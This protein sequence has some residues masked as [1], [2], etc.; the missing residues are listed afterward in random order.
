MSGPSSSVIKFKDLVHAAMPIHG[1]KHYA[2]FDCINKDSR[3][4]SEHNRKELRA[5][6]LSL[7]SLGMSISYI[8]KTLSIARY[9]IYRWLHILIDEGVDSAIEGHKRGAPPSTVAKL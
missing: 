8:A 2:L 9:S 4:K 6:A 1:I 5:L 7:C 3:S